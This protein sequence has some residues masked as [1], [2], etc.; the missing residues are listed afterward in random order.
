MYAV[1]PWLHCVYTIQ[2]GGEG[3]QEQAALLRGLGRLEHLRLI[4]QLQLSEHV[5][6]TRTRQPGENREWGQALAS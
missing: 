1:A 2:R 6:I 4:R 3:V 5:A